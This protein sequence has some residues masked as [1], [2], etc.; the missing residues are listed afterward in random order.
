MDIG[1][2]FISADYRLLIPCTDHDILADV[3]NLFNYLSS[4]EMNNDLKNASFCID[5]SRL[6]VAGASAVANIAYLAAVHA[7]PKPKAVFGL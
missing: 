7:K 2:A 6:V 3:K 1:W 4:D 5:S